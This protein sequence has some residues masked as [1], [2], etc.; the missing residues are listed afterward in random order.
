MN[1][2]RVA[3]LQ[4]NPDGNDLAANQAKGEAFCRRAAAMGADLALFPEMWSAGYRPAL[5]VEENMELLLAPARWTEE[6]RQQASALDLNQVWQE[7]AVGRE[8]PFIRHFQALAK[9]LRMAIAITYLERWPGFPRNAVSVIDRNGEMLMTYAKVHTCAWSPDEAAITPGDGFSVCPLETE[10]G[11]V[12]LGTMICYDREF[13]E[14]ARV[15]MLKGAEI[16]LTPNACDME[17]HRL[18]QFQT[19]A[20]ENMICVA[21]ANYAG[22]RWG[23]SVA[24]DPVAFDKHGSRNTLVIEAGESEGIYLANFDLDAIRDYR[25]RESW[26]NAFRRPQHYGAITAKDINEPFIRA[27]HR[28]ER[29]DPNTPAQ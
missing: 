19:R 29:Y 28:G 22:P 23:H 2:F 1:Y 4:L 6:Q 8:D 20:T 26:G 11:P 9:E 5:Q 15:L 24:Y 10:N 27:N 17:H 12:M 18:M 7:L 16:I 14:S 21:M 3:L 25:Q 13:P